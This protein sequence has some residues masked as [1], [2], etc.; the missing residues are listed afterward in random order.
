VARIT[1]N[2]FCCTYQVI[3]IITRGCI[4]EG[5]P[6]RSRHPPIQFLLIAAGEL[7]VLIPGYDSDFM[8]ALTYIYDVEKYDEQ[9]RNVH[10][11]EALVIEK[12]QINL[13]ACCT[14]SFLT[15]LMPAGAW[16]QGF[17]S[18]VI[19]VYSGHTDIQPLDL[20]GEATR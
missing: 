14:P 3:Q 10:K 2:A 5:Y 9:F 12:P 16:E 6:H 7:G 18:R 20:L 13:L 19:I 15:E 11:G 1:R 4:S 8:N 17:L